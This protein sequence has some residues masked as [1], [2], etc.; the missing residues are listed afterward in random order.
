MAAGQRDQP[1]SSR[2]TTSTQL[3]QR[4]VCALRMALLE[5]AADK[6]LTPRAW[7]P[8]PSSETPATGFRLLPAPLQGSERCEPTGVTAP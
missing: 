4:H 3:V 1:S 7:P 8:C 2:V 5:H 6:E